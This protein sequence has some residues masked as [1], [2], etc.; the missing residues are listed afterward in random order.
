LVFV[1]GG[2]FLFLFRHSL[3]IALKRPI[4]IVY[5][6]TPTNILPNKGIGSN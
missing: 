6:T 2:S 1:N 4:A 3:D 5:T